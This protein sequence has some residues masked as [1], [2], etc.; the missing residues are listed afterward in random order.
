M[1]VGCIFLC[2]RPEYP[3]I[4]QLGVLGWLPA[5]LLLPE[6][7]GLGTRGVAYQVV[8]LPADC[9]LA[10]QRASS[11]ILTIMRTSL[12]GRLAP[13]LLWRSPCESGLI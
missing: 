1:L 10:A 12:P 5:V 11:P 8:S 3:S 13:P 7:A 9:S 2:L 6:W 4:A